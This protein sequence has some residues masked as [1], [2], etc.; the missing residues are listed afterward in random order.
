MKLKNAIKIVES[1]K[2]IY[3]KHI[4][5]I[6]RKIKILE[7]RTKKKK[8]TGKDVTNILDKIEKWNLVLKANF[9]NIKNSS[10]IN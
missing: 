9:W 8:E 2:I 4:K 6:D 3:D 7:K 10:G 5:E 1:G